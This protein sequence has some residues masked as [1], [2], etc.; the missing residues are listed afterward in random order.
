MT[1]EISTGVIV[2]GLHYHSRCLSK[3][4][5]V[6]RRLIPDED[7]ENET[8]K[9]NETLTRSKITSCIFCGKIRKK[10]KLTSREALHTCDTIQGSDSILNAAKIKKDA[11][12]TSLGDDLTQLNIKYHASCRK[13]YMRG[14]Q[15]NEENHTIRKIHLM[16]FDKL[17]QYINEEI[18]IKQIPVMT[19]ELLS[20]YSEEFISA[21]GSE[22]DISYYKTQDLLNKIKIKYE[23]KV[24][25]NKESN[26]SGSFI[27]SNSISKDEAIAIINQCSV[28]MQQIRLAALTLRNEIL[29]ISPQTRPSPCFIS[30]LKDAAPVI[31]ELVETFFDTMING[32]KSDPQQSLQGSNSRST[33]MSADAVFNTTKGH[34]RPWKHQILG[35]GMSTLT[36]SKQVITILNRSGHSISYSEVKQLETEIAFSCSSSG[37]ETPDGLKLRNDLST[38]WYIFCI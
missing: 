26:K 1:G 34:V 25:V 14:L 11:N 13:L 18:I 20:L 2:E 30:T 8:P 12:I 10:N 35:L 17:S 24:S 31:P 22:D 33:A 32:I 16:A 3:Y 36:S 27:H 15:T 29:S 5:A 9:N 4:S 37:R 23:K 38:G 28:K 19:S 6:K 7:P 21:G